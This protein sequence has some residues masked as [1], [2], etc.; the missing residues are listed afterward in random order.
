MT[1]AVNGGYTRENDPPRYIY[2]TTAG[3]SLDLVVSSGAFAGS[4]SY[5]ATDAT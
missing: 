2:G 3:N 1:F 4:V 5:W